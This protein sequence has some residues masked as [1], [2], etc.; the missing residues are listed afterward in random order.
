[1]VSLRTIE[2]T[3]HE[4][5]I[6]GEYDVS[7]RVRYGQVPSLLLSAAHCVG[8]CYY[9]LGRI[10]LENGVVTASWITGDAVL[11]AYPGSVGV[12]YVRSVY[13][14]LEKVS[15]YDLGKSPL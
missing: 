8:S 5:V 9:L 2:E 3:V 14:C 12:H 6:T 7:Q 13:W 11:R 15:R 10:Q 1:M 4:H